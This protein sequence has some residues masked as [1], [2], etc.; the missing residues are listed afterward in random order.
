M[1]NSSP[2]SAIVLYG[3]AAFDQTQNLT[4]LAARLHEV[5]QPDRAGC[6]ITTAFADLTGPSLPDVLD[7]LA[8]AGIEDTTVVTCMVP[9]D[10][11]L[12]T[13]LAGALSQWRADR[14]AAMTVRLAP[15]VEQA[16]DMAAAVAAVLALPAAGDVAQVVPSLGKPGW[17]KIPEHGRQVFFCV[18]ARCLHR[19]AE[20]LYQHLRSAMKSHRALAAGPRR[21]MCARSSCLYPC[22]LGPLMTV[23]PDG[24]WYG[25]LTRERIDRIVAEHLLGDVRVEE[26]V[27]HAA[28][29]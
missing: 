4:Q 13:W 1:S 12:S 10:P 28:V 22:N 24:V 7:A 21:V 18:G 23:H 3:R 11:S 25:G 29:K 26:C 15:P 19:A 16:I 9:A 17:S 27:V 20:P 8:A 2:P 14:G 5:L 6:R